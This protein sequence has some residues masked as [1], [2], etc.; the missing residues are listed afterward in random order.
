MSDPEQE[1]R[2]MAEETVQ[3][4]E[5]LDLVRLSLD[6]RIYVKMRGDRELRGK[7]HAYDQHM[8]MVLG[9]VEESI[10][11]VHLDENEDEESSEIVT[12]NY[13][14]LFVRGDGVILVAPPKRT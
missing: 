8:N 11:V 9:E 4:T 3:T 13:E 6:E 7:L 1:Q 14:M 10:T 12:K 2:H 5:P